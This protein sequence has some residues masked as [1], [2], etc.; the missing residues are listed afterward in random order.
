V[1]IAE[2]EGCPRQIVRYG[3]YVYGFQTHMEF[4]HEIVAA[5]IADAGGRLNCTGKYVQTEEQLLA[6]DYSEMN[7]LL[8]SFLDTMVGEYRR[9]HR[10]A[11]SQ[12]MK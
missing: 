2:S 5:G 8:S 1:I 9:E 7:A 12:V 4:T 10:P 6:F 3:K 11:V